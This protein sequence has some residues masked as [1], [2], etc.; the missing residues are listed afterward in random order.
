MIQLLH[1]RLISL[2]VY[3]FKGLDSTT[4]NEFIRRGVIRRTERP[5]TCNMR[6][7]AKGDNCRL[8]LKETGAE[9]KEI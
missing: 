1:F 5:V 8:V 2:E 4:E 9:T 6:F 7:N 3:N